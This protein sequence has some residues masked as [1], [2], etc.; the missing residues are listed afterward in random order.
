MKF[1]ITIF[2]LSFSLHA[3]I[4]LIKKENSD[5]NT[6]LL[7]IGG[8]HGDEPGGYETASI[9]ATNYTI[10]SKNLWIIPNLNKNSIR[11]NERGIN[12]D[13]NRKF[14]YIRKDDRDKPIIDEIKKIILNKQVSLILNLHDG[15]GF[16]REKYKNSILNPK[17]WGQTCV[18]DQCKL[19][20][21]QE[22]GNLDEIASLVKDRVNE[23]LLN[24]SHEFNV[25]NTNTKI[26]DKQMQLSLTFFAVRHNKPA[27]A[28]ETSKILKTVSEKVFYQLTAI[29][30]FMNIVG[31]KFERNFDLNIQ[32]IS[33]IVKNYGFLNINDNIKLDLT[34]IKNSLSYI[35]IKSSNN[36]FK[37]SNP[38]GDIEK[39]KN[40]YD[41]YIA[42]KKIVSLKPQYF[43]LSNDC[44]DRFSAVV[45]GKMVSL[46]TA[47]NIRVKDSFKIIKQ[48]GI[49]VN[50]IGFSAKNRKDE[51]GIYINKKNIYRSFSID[52]KK[53]VYRIEFY[54]KDKFCSMS[55][56]TFE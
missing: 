27:F 2:L 1:F 11:N 18:I 40:R 35:P 28:I 29:E 45:D 17:A 26:D 10:T 16:Y 33:K 44:F 48:K 49:R 5:S 37:F 20:T 8:I 47:S 55:T 22:F 39:K 43:K 42:S 38:L 4:Q 15:H 12:G 24:N 41:V 25:K 14:A 31:I 51:S 7:I 3:D 19:D 9:L 13:M 36:E 21:N 32:S 53:R 6:T 34:N 52:K 23:D 56:V 54:K 46:P 30:E 50:V